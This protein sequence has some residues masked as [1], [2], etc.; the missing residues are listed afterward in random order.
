MA[1]SA[2]INVLTYLRIAILFETMRQAQL[3][4][5]QKAQI[6]INSPKPFPSNSLKELSAERSRSLGVLGES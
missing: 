6:Y 1:H 2:K 4:F 3:A 5:H